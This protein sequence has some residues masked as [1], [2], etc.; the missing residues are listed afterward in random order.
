MAATPSPN[1]TQIHRVRIVAGGLA[2]RRADVA[3]MVEG[4]GTAAA[5]IEMAVVASE[6]V[7]EVNHRDRDA[8][9][10]A[11]VARLLTRLRQKV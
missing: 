9:A 2:S 8:E 10:T 1:F 7:V 6:D 4:I 5:E 11:A 3:E